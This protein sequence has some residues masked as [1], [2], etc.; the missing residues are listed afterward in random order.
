MIVFDSLLLSDYNYTHMG[1]ID[2]HFHSEVEPGHSQE[3]LA[4]ENFLPLFHI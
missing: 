4:L 3:A 1:V 2:F